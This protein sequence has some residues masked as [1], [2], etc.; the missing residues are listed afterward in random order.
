MAYKRRCHE[1]PRLLIADAYTIG[2]DAF[3]S[4]DARRKSIYYFTFRRSLSSINTTLYREGDNRMLFFGLQR[5]IERIFLKPVTH[6]EIDAAAEY[7][8]NAK[9]TTKGLAPFWFPEAMWRKVVDDYNGYPP[10][11]IIAVPEGSVVYPNEPIG[12]IESMAPYDEN[13]GELAAWFESKLLQVWASSER[14]TQDRH[15]Y[16]RIRELIT[17]TCPEYFQEEVNFFASIMLHDFGDRSGMNDR[18]SEDMALTALYTFNGTDTFAGA[19]QAFLNSNKTPGIGTSVNAL[20][21]RNVQA[22]DNEREAYEAI[23]DASEDN[24]L[25]SMVNDC[26]Y[27]RKA[28]KEYQL[29]LA[30]KGATDGSN[31]VVVSRPDSGDPFEEIM[32]ILKTAVEAGLYTTKIHNGIEYKYATNLRFLEGDGMTYE[33]MW[34]IMVRL[35]DAGFIPWGWGLFGQ[36]GG[37]RNSLKR[38][39]FGAKYALCAKGIYLTPVVKF[40]DTYGK[41]T[42]PGPFKLLRD[43]ESMTNKETIVFY[44]EGVGKFD[45]SIKKDY[46]VVYYDGLLA[47]NSN[48]EGA[49]AGP[50]MEDDFMTIKERSHKQ[51]DTYPLTLKT[52]KNHNFPASEMILQTRRKILMKNAPDKNAEDY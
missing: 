4:L 23:F 21:H 28:V 3:Q 25:V 20:A 6:A 41:T 43:F 51:F 46:R 27:S 9:I 42:L 8:A 11:K 38:D 50:G 40:S 49:W 47:K 33:V 37:Q 1:T 29:P 44:N 13:M 36:G 15:W 48:E 17:K 30:I 12:E 18:E 45:E 14:G 39:D 52:E 5:V 26:Y 10:I 22:Y 31:R 19:Y 32:Y 16:S 7:L 2:A 34:D 35:I 24:E